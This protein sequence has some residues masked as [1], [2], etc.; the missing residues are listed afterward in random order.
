MLKCGVS[1]AIFCFTL[2]ME[3]MQTTASDSSTQNIWETRSCSFVKM[4][5]ELNTNV[6]MLTGS[7]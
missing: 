6:S 5:F 4:Y 3:D 7:Q 2:Q 1:E